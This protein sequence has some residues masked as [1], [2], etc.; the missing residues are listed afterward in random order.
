[1]TK[2]IPFSAV[3]L[4]LGGSDWHIRAGDAEASRVVNALAKAMSLSAEN[5]L[6]GQHLG[7]TQ[8]ELL[9]FVN[10][11]KGGPSTGGYSSGPVF[12]FIPPP[13]NHDILVI[14]MS[15]I[16][17]AIAQAEL[18]RGGFL[19]H[20]ALA[21]TPDYLGGGIILAGPGTVGKTTAINRLPTPW[22]PLSDD[23]SLVVPDHTGQYLAYPWPT[24]S[25][26][27][28]SPDGKSGQGGSWDVQTGLPLKA[29]FFLAQAKDDRI[30]QLPVTSAV[31]HLM[32]TIQHVSLLI[33]QDLPSEQAQQ[34]Y[35]DQLTAA[36][37]CVRAIPAYTLHLS[38]TGTFWNNIEETLATDPGVSTSGI[39]TLPMN[40]KQ[41]TYNKNSTPVGHT[42]AVN[43]SG[44]SMN[45][46]LRHPDLLEIIPYSGKRVKR[47]DIVY[48]HPPGDG[49]KIIHRV[50][51]VS[52]Q[53]I[54]TRGDNN[55]GN[56]PYSLQ[57][58][59]IIGRVTSAWR[60][61]KRRR[62]AGGLPGSFVGYKT[63]LLLRIRR[64]LSPFLHRPYTYVAT[65]GI[66]CFLLPNSL[67]PRVYEF[68][69][70]NPPSLFKVMIKNHVIGYY[71]DWNNLWIIN[72]PWKLVVDPAKLPGISEEP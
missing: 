7:K 54:Y 19:L 53:G 39:H 64:F 14:G 65:K 63:G 1:M 15:L 36:E 27:F 10:P 37:A 57:P 41:L 32:E 60:N 56:D 4:S 17:A 46:T 44:T 71:D 55:A 22:R 34:N 6:P 47:G 35:M 9:V 2:A 38:L 26:F 70:R 49:P 51:Q 33:T 58:E 3:N 28:N 20:G 12:C 23:T 62:I 18:S 59:D 8:R 42:M 16:G 72:R 52:D 29:V 13:E 45:P 67:R 40:G 21:G 50:V 31:T 5:H 48:F 69:Q 11:K 68:K 25:R 30:R 24:W 43:Y 61:C 66:F